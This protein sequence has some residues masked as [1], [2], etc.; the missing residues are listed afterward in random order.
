MSPTVTAPARTAC[1]SLSLGERLAGLLP[2]RAGQPWTVTPATAWWTTKPAARLEQCGRALIV[3]ARPWDTE[4]AWE[5]P[6][7]TPYEPD[8]RLSRTDPVPVAREV[9]RLVLPVVDD[10]VA[11]ARV[12]GPRVMGRLELLNEI[13]AAMRAQGAATYNRVGLLMDT[14]TLAW[15]SGGL[16]FS[17]TMHGTNP[18]CD[19]Q[20]QGPVRAV[21]RAVAHFLP[22]PNGGRQQAPEGVRGRLQRRIGAYLARCVDIE[23]TE[24][25]G[26]AFGTRPG[27][28]GYAAPALDPAARA[29]DTAPASVDLH[30]VGVDLLVS[31]APHLAR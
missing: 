26:I 17:V 4:V 7:R 21:E 10:E 23:Q 8:L 18:V 15:G 27:P 16:N 1:P 19:I 28:Y 11:G 9:L 5:L 6:G 3:V 24:G 14:S 31:L 13:G 25:G 22:E 29:H 2:A 20:M 12:G 30:G